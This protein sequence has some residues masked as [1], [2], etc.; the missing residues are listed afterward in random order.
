MN[1]LPES[2]LAKVA[3]TGV[4]CVTALGSE[5]GE[6]WTKL[7]NGESARA[8]L[9]AIAVEGCRVTDGAQAELPSLP[10]MHSGSL[11][12][13]SRAARLA[14][15]AAKQAL[16]QAGLL[17]SD[18][19]CS[20][21]RLEMSVSTTACGM[22]KGEEFLRELWARR[23]NGQTARVSHYQSQQQI[24]ALH[25]A[26]GFDGPSM[27]VANA[28]AGGANAIGHG[29]D[30]IGAGL[31]NI[32]LAGGYDALS[33]L[34]FAGFDGLQ[35]L[36]PD[37][38]RPFDRGRR[39]LMLGEGAAFLVLEDESRA[40]ARG[41]GILGYIAGYGHST[42]T[43]HL[44]QPASD[45]A[46]LERAMRQALERSGIDPAR[47]GYVNAHG[48]GTPFNDGAEAAAF[49]RVFGSFST[50]LSSTKAALGHTLGAAGAIEA[51]LCLM[52]LQTGQLPPQ[53]NL[54]DPEPL[55]ASALVKMG[56]RS[57]LE[58]TMSI[59]LGFGGSNA[60]LL[61]HKP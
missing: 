6:T 46:P 2:T 58:A 49:H 50:R 9:T 48:T 4:G 40:T 31:A 27:V 47:V 51:V 18:G 54:L 8:P 12:Y 41:A 26:F 3:V 24:S 23:R 43:H 10:W 16:A 45:G 35:A 57:N 15:P 39:G 42:D 30:L 14:L 1:A 11:R 7:C 37:A 44:T 60:A 52:S 61:F 25:E 19:K 34:V 32:V 55:V 36:A 13:A 21:R 33:E 29:F 38:C 59:N 5:V 28:C 53:I 17:G 56:E 20:L 22:E